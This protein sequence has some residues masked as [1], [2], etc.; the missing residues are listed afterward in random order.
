MGIDEFHQDLIR[1]WEDQ[2]FQEALQIAS[3]DLMDFAKKFQNKYVEFP[4]K[5]K[6]SI[7]K[8]A[9]RICYRSTPF[10]TFTGM[11]IGKWD[12]NSET[13]IDKNAFLPLYLTIEGHLSK[14]SSYL[15]PLSYSFGNGTRSYQRN[16]MNEKNNWQI[17]ELEGVG[18]KELKKCLEK[19]SLHH[20]NNSNIANDSTLELEEELLKGGF[21]VDSKLHTSFV[22]KSNDNDFNANKDSV[23]TIYKDGFKLDRKLQKDLNAAIDTLTNLRMD[24]PKETFLNFKRCFKERFEYRSVPILEALDPDLGV[25]Y[26]FNLKSSLNPLWSNVHGFLL[27]K[28]LKNAAD[29]IP[30]MQICIPEV[31]T[32]V[33]PHNKQ[34]NES[35]SVLFSAFEKLLY[36]KQVVNSAIPLIGRMTIYDDAIFELAK[37]LT[38]KEEELESGYIHADIIYK[39]EELMYKVGITKPLRNHQLLISPINEDLPHSLEWSDLYLKIHEKELVLFS[40]SFKKR[41]IPHLNSAYNYQR[42]ELPLFRLLCDLQMEGV[43]T[44][45]GFHLKHYFPNQSQ[46]PEVRIEDVIVQLALWII[47]K[48][49]LIKINSGNDLKSKLCC[50][51]EYADEVKLPN[52]FLL[53]RF[54]Q[55]LVF[56]RNHEEELEIFFNEIKSFIQVEME[57]FP[58]D[59]YGSKFKNDDGKMYAHELIA[60]YFE[61]DLLRT[62][63]MN[64]EVSASQPLNRDPNW[65]TFN[66]YIQ[67]EEQNR[68]MVEF[69]S[70]KI[71]KL[72]I[73]EWFF[74]RYQDDKGDHLRIR[75]KS[76]DVKDQVSSFLMQISKVPYVKHVA[77]S[78]YDAEIYRYRFLGMKVSYELFC[79]SSFDFLNQHLLLDFDQKLILILS[80]WLF[81]IKEFSDDFIAMITPFQLDFLKINP[82]L[83]ETWDVW[84]RINKKSI[85]LNH[86]STFT[87]LLKSHI[88]SKSNNPKKLLYLH[89][90]F[91]M[92]MNRCFDDHQNEYEMKLYYLLPK[93]INFLK[94][95]S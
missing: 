76:K 17:Q 10:G 45:Q 85:V 49:I 58:W 47:P 72:K 11:G 53:K 88:N 66:V 64:F 65:I 71:R 14:C 68:F 78:V 41:V 61:N 19:N 44:Q 89:S 12:S 13:I 55:G 37:S 46:Y 5:L 90:M 18:L 95:R 62:K 15:N 94:Y 27:E 22:K 79:Q 24:A 69:L 3:P 23:H 4:P 83:R 2:T 9:N 42:D 77:L 93:A 91:H 50:F 7:W 6:H 54:D 67:K 16:L 48:D 70:N 80:E 38:V 28:L 60:F 31:D 86:P 32:L 74:I 39:G 52:K 25:A 59:K 81:I 34:R 20:V 73:K 84:F 8:Y 82:S 92:Q 56:N 30:I 29:G 33:Y 1:F 57:D 40:K 35:Q 87:I 21:L 51:K 43:K 36:V 26:Q 75:F 63:E